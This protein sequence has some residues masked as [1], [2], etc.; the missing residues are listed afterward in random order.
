MA[1][2]IEKSGKTVQHAINDALEALN[3]SADDVVIEVLDEGEPGGI[4]GIGRKP[5]KVRVTLDD[6]QTDAVVEDA[7]TTPG[8]ANRSDQDDVYYGDDDE[9]AEDSDEDASER[10]EDSDEIGLESPEEAEAT[11]YV[12][13]IL[14]GIGIHGRISSYREDNTVYID[15]NGE[16][17][18]A[19]IGRR[20]ETLDA[21]QYLATLVANKNSEERVRVMLD[22][23]GYRR[24]R[25]D[26]L[27]NL[28]DRTARKVMKS[29]RPF[30]LQA[31]S[32]A[33][34]RIVHSSLQQFDGIT[35]YSEGDDPQRR[36]VIAPASDHE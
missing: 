4:L 16:D 26:S 18:G 6:M 32:P 13:S 28:A 1:V 30:R 8:M 11:A 10:D 27:I 3:A 2:S 15:V 33:E 19:A 20:G 36:V 25:E 21:L 23:D 31:M 22:I 14:S 17:C 34:R 9:L 24:R 29:G 5:A 12:A 7:A 35:T